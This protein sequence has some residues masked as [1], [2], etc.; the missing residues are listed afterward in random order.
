MIFFQ[1][2]KVFLARHQCLNTYIVPISTFYANKKYKY[3]VG[4]V[5]KEQ[6]SAHY[7]T[8]LSATNHRL[9]TWVV[10]RMSYLAFSVVG[11]LLIIHETYIIY[12]YI[13]KSKVKVILSKAGCTIY[14]I[15]TNENKQKINRRIRFFCVLFDMSIRN[16][17]S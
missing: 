11:S 16:R 13:L 2:F 3:Y 8:L 17:T 10:I 1:V 7:Q 14:L 6:K 9:I 15:Q 4:S 5:A 12:V